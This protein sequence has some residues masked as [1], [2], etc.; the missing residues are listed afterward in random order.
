MGNTNLKQV[1]F[2]VTD[3]QRAAI[4]RLQNQ[5]PDEVSLGAFLRD[6][7]GIACMRHDIHWPDEVESPGGDRWSDDYAD[8]LRKAQFLE[9]VMDIDETEKE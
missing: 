8:H 4:Q 9:R 5:L 1:K 3:N 6:L 7:V 2:Y